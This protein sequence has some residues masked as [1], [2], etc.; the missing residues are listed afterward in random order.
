MSL[1][2]SSKLQ[3]VNALM[4]QHTDRIASAWM[5]E[6]S[7]IKIFEHHKI[8]RKKFSSLF[9]NQII[10]YFADVLIGKQL[11]GRC[12]VM[13]KFIDYMISRDITIKEIF[14]ICMA[15]RKSMIH[16]L[17]LANVLD[18]KEL[19][20]IDYLADIFDK[21]LSGVLDYYDSIDK[22]KKDVKPKASDIEEYKKPFEIMMNQ[23]DL[24]AVIIYDHQPFVAN[25]A[26]FDLAGCESIEDYTQTHTSVWELFD[27]V[28]RFTETYES[29]QYDEWLEELNSQ[30]D[31]SVTITRNRQEEK[32]T[33]RYNVV[34]KKMPCKYCTDIDHYCAVFY[35]EVSAANVDSQ[36]YIDPLTKIANRHKFDEVLPEWV[37]NSQKKKTPISIIVI[38][39]LDLAHINKMYGSEMG[40]VVL[41]EFADQVNIS[42]GEYGL[43]AR[44]EGNKFALIC[45]DTQLERAVEYANVILSAGQS[46]IFD[47]TVKL[48]PKF[49]VAVAQFHSQDTIITVCGR[50]NILLNE[51]NKAGSNRVKDDSKLLKEEAERI[52]LEEKFLN[53]CSLLIG[54]KETLET[55]NYYKEVPIG[56]KAIIKR[57]KEDSIILSIRAIAIYALH[58]GDTVFIKRAKGEKTVRG[59]VLNI[60]KENNFI[61]LGSFIFIMSSPLDRKS[62]HVQLESAS[63]AKLRLHDK[64]WSGELR[65]ISLTSAEIV[66][67]NIRGLTHDGEIMLQTELRWDEFRKPLNTKASLIK[68]RDT[69]SGS[70][71]LVLRLMLTTHQEE[72]VQTFVSHRQREIVQELQSKILKL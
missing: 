18:G 27:T 39:M 42:F 15:F 68:I 70:F 62:V 58:N 69:H 60:D 67:P 57:V 63:V 20:L 65:S 61:E 49:S 9:A 53:E 31:H 40:D 21:N 22:D 46:I 29:A 7:V 38:E 26:F 12:P 54:T 13:N 6:E 14:V 47:E 23:F 56:S 51:I 32:N 24:P 10:T 1:V 36:S 8:S 43:F 19:P 71:T 35:P 41:E 64:Q 5:H 3:H 45:K 72:F 2:S 44:I 16:T 34:I 59:R 11:V 37:K 50:L 17:A 55:T 66:L 30:D 33:Q 4:V 28:N 48:S 52:K 25:K